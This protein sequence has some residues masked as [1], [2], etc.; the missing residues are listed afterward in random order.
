MF[1]KSAK[2][3]EKLKK[4][5]AEA[6][7]SI[8]DKSMTVTGEIH[9]KGKARIDGTVKGN[10]TGEHLVLSESG[11]IEGDLELASFNCFGVLVGNIKTGLLTARK[12]CSL[13]GKLTAESLTVE[14][15]A[16]I[17]G[18][19]KASQPEGQAQ[20]VTATPPTTPTPSEPKK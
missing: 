8:I 9:F 10:I 12:G 13:R 14:P 16:H 18:E 19:I 3:E 1:S 17:E 7:A 20:K 2:V 6:V 5:D 15:G 11:I 4:I